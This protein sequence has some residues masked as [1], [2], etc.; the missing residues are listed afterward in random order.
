MITPIYEMGV[1]HVC[2]WE[3]RRN[4]GDT[5]KGTTT[6]LA[7][8]RVLRE[9]LEAFKSKNSIQGE[10]EQWKSKSGRQEMYRVLLHGCDWKDCE[11]ER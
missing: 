9:G 2:K 10:S 4:T 5:V 11:S 7:K 3:G 6:L 1:Q 8:Q